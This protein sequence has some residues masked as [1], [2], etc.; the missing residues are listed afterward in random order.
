MSVISSLKELFDVVITVHLSERQ[1]YGFFIKPSFLRY[2]VDRFALFEQ[3]QGLFYVNR[4]VIWSLN[5]FLNQVWFQ[6]QSKLRGDVQQVT[7]TEQRVM[8]KVR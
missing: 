2:L 4:A 5:V 6:E 8:S 7:I 3:D 1:V